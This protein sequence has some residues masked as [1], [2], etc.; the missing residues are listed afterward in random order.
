MKLTNYL[1]NKGKLLI[2]RYELKTRKQQL[3]NNMNFIFI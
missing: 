2:F 1:Q 3:K